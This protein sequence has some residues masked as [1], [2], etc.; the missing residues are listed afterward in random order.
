[1]KHTSSRLMYM[2]YLHTTALE[3]PSILFLPPRL[4]YTKF[5]F[6]SFHLVYVPLLQLFCFVLFLRPSN[7]FGPSGRGDKYEKERGY[8][9]VHVHVLQGT[10]FILYSMALN[11]VYVRRIHHK[12]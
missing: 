12:S 7:F 11:H 5:I 2:Q 1:M 9:Y 6:S 10:F 8:K 3:R 4:K